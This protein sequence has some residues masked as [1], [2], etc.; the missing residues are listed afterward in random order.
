MMAGLHAASCFGA[1]FVFCLTTVAA[2]AQSQE[3]ESQED[4]SKLS[5]CSSGSLPEQIMPRKPWV[6]ESSPARPEPSRWER[7]RDA[8]SPFRQKKAQSEPLKEEDR[9][10]WLMGRK[11]QYAPEKEPNYVDGDD[12]KPD[13]SV[14]RASYD[15]QQESRPATSLPTMP[16]PDSLPPA[17]PDNAGNVMAGAT[18][19]G[20]APVAPPSMLPATDQPAIPPSA[21]EATEPST[22]SLPP[23]LTPEPYSL[24]KRWV[25]GYPTLVEWFPKHL[26]PP[27]VLPSEN[28]QQE[29]TARAGERSGGGGYESPGAPRR[30]PPSP[31]DSPPFPGSE[32]Q[33]YPLI[34]TPTNPGIDPLY[35]AL[36][37]GPNGEAIRDSRVEVH[38]W[39]T[40]SGNWSNAIHSNLP[41]AY[42]VVPNSFQLD[43]AVIKFEREIDWVQTDHIDWGFR[44]VHL[45]GIDYRYTTAGGWFSQQLLYHNNLYGYDPVELWGEVYIPKI[46]EGFVIRMGRW[47]AC[48]DI[49]AQYAP[50]NYLA[51]HSLL[52]TYDTYTQTGIM[53]SCQVNQR[54]MIQGAIQSGTDMA[55]WY[56]GATPTG[57][58]GWRWVS[59]SN[60]D[61]FYTCLNN[62]NDA[63]FR[64]FYA[65][66]RK[67]GHDNFN[68]IVTTWE[69][70]F[71][72]KVHT[73]TEAYY[74]WQ[75]NAV[76]GGTPSLGA[77]D[78]FG[79]G[80]G[81]GKFLPGNSP[82]YGVLN[83][84]MFQLSKRDYLTIR[85]EWWDDQRGERTG[86]ATNYTSDT[87]G[88]SHQFNDLVMIR[89]E[90]GFY[91]SWNVPAFD[92]G[93]KKNLLMY[94]F[95]FTVRF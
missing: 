21:P 94:G 69:H 91:R 87:I 37:L 33:G 47:I 58:F 61:A 52:F 1:A 35:Q 25:R 62:I 56:P 65:D 43:Q 49:E 13:L 41:L 24:M 42:W 72:Q 20:S 8:I 80:G 60:N 68:Y 4:Q 95:D 16:S 70:R 55:P 46:F 73:K 48:P 29:D 5:T 44:S 39:V 78:G 19:T 6:D 26:G 11:I 92:L 71:S 93:T 3:A 15:L 10:R 38:G 28:P 53:F 74:M 22:A 27:R 2:V 14:L 77:P 76:V 82:A 89:P 54:N 57:F 7:F 9:K 85:N 30:S 88:I 45:Y 32:Y 50:D 75:F 84:T 23:A 51:S 79:G 83:Y 90:I 63:K 17:L 64:Y 40:T 34:G 67:A 86:F 18:N 59:K 12:V 81:L 36:L 31:W 66:G